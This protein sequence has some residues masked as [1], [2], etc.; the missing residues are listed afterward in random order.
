MAAKRSTLI[1]AT[2]GVMTA[3]LLY[4]SSTDQRSPDGS[5][6][7]ER[8]SPDTAERSTFPSVEDDHDE[9]EFTSIIASRGIKASDPTPFFVVTRFGDD[10]VSRENSVS[11]ESDLE[12]FKNDVRGQFTSEEIPDL[13][14]ATSAGDGEAAYVLYVIYM[15]CSNTLSVPAS[16]AAA[17]RLEGMVDY[18][19]KWFSE[20]RTFCGSVDS[21]S[22]LSE[23]MNWLL[24]AADLRY[25][26]AML[27]LITT[28]FYP[29]FRLASRGQYD[30]I[31][32]YR[33]A[34]FR[35]LSILQDAGVPVAFEVIGTFIANG[36]FGVPDMKLAYA[37]LRADDL[38]VRDSGGNGL[39][40][41]DHLARFL[42]GAELL[43]AD[44]MGWEIC[45]RYAQG[46]CQ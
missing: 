41:A 1:I 26:P 46:T 39:A 45:Q 43:E 21:Y 15:D 37:Y 23:A 24:V 33:A 40:Y 7:R 13:T 18:P 34:T 30:A 3:A 20:R 25:E 9:T 10:R 42:D 6:T 44:A 17:E 2:V 38:M 11:A 5:E 28:G 35:T 8:T 14:D 19:A 32:M 4:M 36:T 12:A 22:A 16:D 27:R 31:P 29:A